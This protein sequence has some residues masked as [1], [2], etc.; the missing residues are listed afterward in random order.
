M[1]ENGAE[2]IQQPIHLGQGLLQCRNQGCGFLLIYVQ[3]EI[4]SPL[5]NE[6][7]LLTSIPPCGK[8]LLRR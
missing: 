5:V 4:R 1:I 7:T 3:N 6:C 8:N 2:S